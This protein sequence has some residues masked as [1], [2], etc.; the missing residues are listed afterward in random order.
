[1]NHH[2]LTVRTLAITVSMIGL[3]QVVV[4]AQ[5]DTAAE[6]GQAASARADGL[7][8]R[9]A[10]TLIRIA[11]AMGNG[12][13]RGVSQPA[14][15]APT[16]DAC[17]S[18]W[19]GFD[20]TG[21]LSVSPTNS[22][23]NISCFNCV[24][25]LNPSNIG[26]NF[27]E[28]RAFIGGTWSTTMTFHSTIAGPCVVAFLWVN[29]ATRQTISGFASNIPDCGSNNIWLWEFFNFTV[30]NV[31]GDTIAVGIIQASSG[32]FDVDFEQFRI[33]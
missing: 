24:P 16:T 4:P 1:M 31:P 7:T 22:S 28:G 29:A 18:A 17:C 10:S 33:Q 32:A 27:P 12:E 3:A 14:A 11:R 20:F 30:P 21:V 2:W 9:D 8:A 5:Q 23:G 6:T 26:M 19:Q 13:G 25:S 15:D